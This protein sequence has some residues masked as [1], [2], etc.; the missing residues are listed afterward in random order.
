MALNLQVSPF[1]TT[2]GDHTPHSRTPHSRTPR[3]RSPTDPQALQPH[4]QPPTD[5]CGLGGSPRR[6]CADLVLAVD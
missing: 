5:A 6:R 1:S 3:N 2:N 4:E